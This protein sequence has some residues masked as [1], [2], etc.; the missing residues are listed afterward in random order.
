MST[1]DVGLGPERARDDRALRVL[2]G[3]LRGE[4]PAAAHLLDERVVLGQALEL[5][6]AQAVGAR[7]ADVRD[8]DVVLADV[9]GGDRRAHPGALLAGLR[10]L[11]D[12]RVGLEHALGEQLLGARRA[13]VA[14]PALEGLDRDPRGDLAGL[15]AAHPVG[16]DEHRRAREVGVLVR[17][18]RAAGVGVGEVVGGDAE[19]QRQSS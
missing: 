19:H 3:L 2:V 13:G 17:A 8:R 10:H 4:L 18:A 7:V 6:A 14:E 5:A 11:V 12:A 9:R 15:R 16:D 1:S